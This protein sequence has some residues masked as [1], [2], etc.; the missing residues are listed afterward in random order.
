MQDQDF[1]A[2]IMASTWATAHRDHR[3]HAHGLLQALHADPGH[4]AAALTT[5]SEATGEPVDHLVDA[6]HGRNTE[7]VAQQVTLGGTRYEDLGGALPSDVRDNVLENLVL[8]LDDV[9]HPHAARIKEAKGQPALEQLIA[10]WGLWTVPNLDPFV[11]A[12]VALTRA[13]LLGRIDG[14]EQMHVS[15]RHL[16]L[17]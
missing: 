10:L 16:G 8:V 14:G 9:K 4:Q 11:F 5:Y 1:R 3:E 2:W 6:L 15:M 7:A 12:L 13:A 17:A